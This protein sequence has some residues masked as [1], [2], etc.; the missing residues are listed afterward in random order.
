MKK[1]LV[2]VVVLEDKGYEVIFSRGKAYS[3]LKHLASGTIKQIGVR[4][5]NLYRLQV[6]TCAA[7]SS[8]A[9]CADVGELWHRRMGHLH[10]GALKILQQIDTG[11]PAC[12][13]DK[14]GV[15][16]GCTLGKYAKSSFHGQ[17]NR[18]KEILEWV[19]SDVCRP[20][21]SPSLMKYRYY[22]TF[23]DDFCRKTWIY[24]MKR[25]MRA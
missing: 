11:I 13:L 19:H 21:S 1:N 9:R 6:E 16:K 14:S 12:S 7:L 18:A 10:H 22:V 20:F 2:S 4:M 25:K 17:E 5:K 24:F 8:K 3:R 15:C 23:I